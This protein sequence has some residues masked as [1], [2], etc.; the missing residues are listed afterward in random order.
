MIHT[1]ITCHNPLKKANKNDFYWLEIIS[2][3]ISVTEVA[4]F[5]E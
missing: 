4:M 1:K 3:T 2:K 5:E